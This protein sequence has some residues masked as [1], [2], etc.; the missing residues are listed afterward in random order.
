MRAADPFAEF[1]EER[2]SSEKEP[3][4][5]TS[6]KRQCNF[7]DHEKS[8]VRIEELLQQHS[9]EYKRKEK[10]GE[11]IFELQRCPENEQHPPGKAFVKVSRSGDVTAGCQH[12]SCKWGFP[13]FYKK[14]EGSWPNGM[15]GTVFDAPTNPPPWL[16]FDARTGKATIL[17]RQ[18]ACDFRKNYPALDLNDPV[19][20]STLNNYL[21][22]LAP[23]ADFNHL[24][25]QKIVKM[26]QIQ[27]GEEP[28]STDPIPLQLEMHEGRSYP[29][30]ALPPDQQEQISELCELVRV[31]V[32][33]AA[34][35]LQAAISYATQ[36][37]VNVVRRLDN[38]ELIGPINTAHLTLAESSERKSSVDNKLMGFLEQH[39]KELRNQ[40][41]QEYKKL[42][43][44]HDQWQQ[45]YQN[46]QA[47]LA[48]IQRKSKLSE[49]DHSLIHDLNRELEEIREAEPF[50]PPKSEKQYLPDLFT[51]N[52]SI[53]SLAQ[54]LSRYPSMILNSAE[55]GQTLG[56]FAFQNDN[57]LNTLA[58]LNELI[59]KGAV[60]NHRVGDTGVDVQNA[61]LTINLMIQPE[62]AMDLYTKPIFRGTGML[63]RFC[64]A[65]PSSMAGGRLID[66]NKALSGEPLYPSTLNELTNQL[67]GLLKT[68]Q[69]DSDRQLVL[70]PLQ[71][72]KA[73]LE[74][75]LEY[76]NQIEKELGAQGIY[77]EYKDVAGKSAEIAARLAAQ[78]HVINCGTEGE[79]SEEFVLSGVELARWYLNEFL[80]V[81]GVIQEDRAF[82]NATKLLNWLK[83]NKK[84]EDFRKG[85]TLDLTT[86]KQFGPRPINRQREHLEEA[87]SL[88][89]RNHY[90][91]FDET[92]KRFKGH[93]K[94]FLAN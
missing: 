39:E 79:I 8:I 20:R 36:G 23:Q 15:N 48:R 59:W 78:F 61:R 43:G 81:S 91:R 73:G 74:M 55:G 14:L 46:R 62:A 31:P 54:V 52:F 65:R 85:H 4:S 33:L 86:L 16:N 94:E 44:Q 83:T 3:N 76:Y 18:A 6:T 11:V 67:L 71:M 30:T 7:G 21:D 89:E 69:L 92:S 28:W 80:R 72:N 77:E 12:D 22:E 13:S 37:L 64:V 9:L 66:V 88:L 56:S 68:T 87:L 84:A 53:Q 1:R 47:A 57:L 90:L 25:L 45:R 41:S 27:I 2:Q 70:K 17:H 75:W 60:R 38:D 35:S 24:D 32:A 50:K 19:A 63:A 49:E 82:L 58:D 51:R 5:S 40:Y 29:I 10:N 34:Q 93:P 42:A 26:A